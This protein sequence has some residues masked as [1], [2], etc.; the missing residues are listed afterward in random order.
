VCVCVS[1][2]VSVCVF[3]VFARVSFALLLKI[4]AMAAKIQTPKLFSSFL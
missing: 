2:C 4:F 1:V 3:G